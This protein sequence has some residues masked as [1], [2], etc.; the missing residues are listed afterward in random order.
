[1][2]PIIG[3]VL[4]YAPDL[5]G[6]FVGQKAGDAADK[7][8]KIAKEVLGTDDVAEAQ[9]KIAAD[10]S[11]A[12]QFIEKVRAETEQFKAALADTADARQQT[13][14]LVQAES[15][16]AWGAAIVSVLVT[17]AFIANI[18]VL[19]VV[20]VNFT[21]ITGQVLLL[22]TGTLSAAFTQVINYWLGSSAGSAAKDLA[23]RQAMTPA[24]VKKGK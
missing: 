15:P 9:A 5:I 20:K 23:I 12:N 2:L 14:Q 10:A 3:L 24:P 17:L 1:M 4:Q 22:L 19:F 6:L 13:I 21:E 16:M 8:I 11:L 18:G 7:V